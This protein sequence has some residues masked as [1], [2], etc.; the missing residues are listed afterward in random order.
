VHAVVC[1][2]EF[3]LC[4]S[5]RTILPRTCCA[6]LPFIGLGFVTLE[7]EFWTDE[8]WIVMKI[9]RGT[10]CFFDR[11]EFGLGSPLDDRF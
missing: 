7:Q 5:R 1:G 6:M 3:V 4:F 2:R 10:G 11:N 8:V 9:K